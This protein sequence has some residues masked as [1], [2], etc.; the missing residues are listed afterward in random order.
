MTAS[1]IY[2]ENPTDIAREAISRFFSD[3]GVEV[4]WA[5]SSGDA[6]VVIDWPSEKKVS[7]EPGLLHSG[8]R[9]TCSD[10]FSTAGKMNTDLKVVGELMN[11]LDIRICACQLG[12]FD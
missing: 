11:H 6:G 1:R 7:C 2:L 5:A 10:A 8:G 12:C 3:N 9:I 4:E